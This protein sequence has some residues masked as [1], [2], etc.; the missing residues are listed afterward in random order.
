MSVTLTPAQQA[1]LDKFEEDAQA[2]ND[3][4]TAND[5]DQAALLTLQ[6]K[7]AIDAQAAVET[8]AAALQSAQEFI[9][10]MLHRSPTPNMPPASVK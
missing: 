4:A 2:A 3:A 7:A 10:L 6:A 9:D 8:H 1:A 5:E